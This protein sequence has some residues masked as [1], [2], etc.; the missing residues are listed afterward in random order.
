MKP[1][2]SRREF[3]KLLGLSGLGMASGCCVTAP[4]IPA[5]AVGL[6]AGL[7]AQD[8]TAQMAA[9]MGIPAIDAHAHFFNASDMQAAGYLSGP[10]ANDAPAAI[11]TLIDILH[12][13]VNLMARRF[14]PSAYQE[15][16]YL[17]TM[18]SDLAGLS[19]TDRLERLDQ[20]II[21][22]KDQI[23]V[24]LYRR[25]QRTDFPAAFQSSML[26]GR[27]LIQDQTRFSEDTVRAALD[28]GLEHDDILNATATFEGPAGDHPAGL[29]AF[30]GNMFHYRVENIRIYQKA[31]ANQNR[32][33]RI[34]AACMAMVDFDYWLDGCDHPPSRLRDQV[35]LMEKLVKVTDGYV[36]PLMA[37]NPWS[38]L[39]SGGESLAL[40][41]EAVS[42]RG[43]VGVK[44]YPPI[45]FEPLGDGS[46]AVK[47]GWP[48]ADKLKP[49]L[50]RFYKKCLDL[51]VPV[52]AH[53]N[54]SMGAELVCKDRSSP[55]SW[56]TLLETPGF[57]RLRINVGHFGGNHKPSSTGH[58]WSDDFVRLMTQ[59]P[60]LFAD[61]GFWDELAAGNVAVVNKLMGLMHSDIGSGQ[62]AAQ[63]IMFG[64]DWFMLAQKKNWP[65][66]A[67]HVR[68]QLESAGA[69]SAEIERLLYRNVLDL[70]GLTRTTPGQNRQRLH[71]YYADN[72][73][74]ADWFS[75]T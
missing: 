15:S 14:A 25:L 8:P 62:Q 44:M 40:L 63:R 75:L 64:T 17:E 45:C 59:A 7:L 5:S 12:P 43:F 71:D 39:N 55:G 60:H 10:I 52:M 46:S 1:V 28:Y 72:G 11:R 29:L 2:N 4:S 34:A 26:D 21:R 18:N 22:R 32:S 38:D 23:A 31:Y 35:L 49:V 48:S 36:L 61:I 68:Q 19:A 42:D 47:K 20:S 74:S 57:E 16:V 24:E 69:G 37:Y 50:E 41:E 66:Y 65:V 33:V 73:I 13:V 54:F 9:S 27:F 56:K 3:L 53:A 67:D 70:Y 30:I 58:F 6:S 51:D